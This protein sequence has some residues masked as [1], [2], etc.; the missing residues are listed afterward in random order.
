MKV[1]LFI[2]LCFSNVYTQAQVQYQFDF[3]ATINQ[4]EL[5]IGTSTFSSVL[6]DSIRIDNLK[7]Y[8]SNLKLLN[9]DKIAYEVKNYFLIDYA[10]KKYLKFKTNGSVKFDA[11]SFDLGI[12]SATHEMGVMEG[13]LD[14]TKGMY[15]TWQSGYIFFKLEGCSKVVDNNKGLFTFHIGG[16][17]QK[18]PTLQHITIKPKDL[19]N[20]IIINLDLLFKNIQWK[21]QS[22]IMSPG[23]KAVEFSKLL[24]S[25]F[26]F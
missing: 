17:N 7:F 4:N 18:Y 9:K 23:E 20:K 16:F 25:L 11:I 10:S 12:D 1:F 14:P 5:E 15:W 24:P 2:I 26:S 21:Q 8:V 22:D 6:N 13:D 19:S 3:F